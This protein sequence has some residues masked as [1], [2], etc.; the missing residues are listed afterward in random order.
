MSSL[1]SETDN[2]YIEF[3]YMKTR[4]HFSTNNFVF[5]NCRIF[6]NN[7]IVD[8]VDL[9]ITRI[10]LV[11][12]VDCTFPFKFFIKVTRK[13]QGVTKFAFSKMWSAFFVLSILPEILRNS[14]RFHL[15]TKFF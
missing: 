2:I 13:V 9:W 5:F 6:K 3:L 8:I 15:L 11:I 4:L 12:G 14:F 7:L 1:E 10:S